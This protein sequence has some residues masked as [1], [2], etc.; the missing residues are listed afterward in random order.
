LLGEIRPDAVALV[1][2]FDFPDNI[3]NSSIGRF[4]GNIYESLL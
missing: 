2:A 4:D 3:L 1:D